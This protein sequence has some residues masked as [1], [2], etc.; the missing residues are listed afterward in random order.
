MT[1]LGARKA[2]LT[3]PTLTLKKPYLQSTNSMV[4]MLRANLS[5]SRLPLNTAAVAAEELLE[6][7]K[8]VH[9]LTELA[10]HA[11]DRRW[12]W[13]NQITDRLDAKD[14]IS[15]RCGRMQE[16]WELI[17][18]SLVIVVDLEIGDLDVVEWV[19]NVNGVVEMTVVVAVVAA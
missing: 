1:K 14:G 11:M 17:D 6:F 13:M 3:S 12:K 15:R 4:R 8:A 10:H 7:L 16:S 5:A 19:A 9:Y 2:L 18:T